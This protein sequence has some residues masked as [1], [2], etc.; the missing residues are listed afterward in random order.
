MK[1]KIWRLRTLLG[2]GVAIKFTALVFALV[3]NWPQLSQGPQPVA[4]GV[5]P[6]KTIL[7]AQA[8]SKPPAP[9]QAKEQKQP[10][11]LAQASSPA[12]QPPKTD[13][14]TAQKQPPA[15]GGQPAMNPR[16]LELIEEK[17]QALALEEQRLAR[18]REELAKLKDEVNQRIAEL[19]KVQASLEQL[20]ATERS[21]R[22]KRIQQLVKV[23]SNMRADSAGAVI[24][25]LDDQMAV[26]IFSHMQ[27]RQ[28]GKVM[29]AINP[30]KAARISLLLTRKKEAE[31]A[32]SLAGDAAVKGGP[33][34]AKPAG[35]AKK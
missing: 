27:S 17:Q 22:M 5:Q 3:L 33:K 30:E 10:Q 31:E 23:L 18:E 1:R 9:N 35:G 24:S 16:I 28:A 6:A 26:E 29:A 15:A 8:Q 14:E 19:K 13:Q 12:S 21:E 20:V 32:G 2:V 25:K 7:K 4:A 34:P 11:Q